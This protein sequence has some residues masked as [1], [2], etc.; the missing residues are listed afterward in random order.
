MKLRLTS[1]LLLLLC[2]FFVYESAI[3]ANYGFRDDYSLTREAH[4]E[5]GKI[6]AFTASHARPLYGVVLEPG[7]KLV[8][9]IDDLAWLR[10]LSAALI[11]G[12]GVALYRQLRR[13][14]LEDL[15]ATAISLIVMC[16]PASQVTVSWAVGWPWGF[17]LIFTV[18][19]FGL[20]NTAWKQMGF[21]RAWRIAIAIVLYMSSTLIYQSNTLFVVALL[22]SVLLLTTEKNIENI[23]KNKKE[24]FVIFHLAIL[25][26]ALIF[27]YI[28][29]KLL[30]I[31]GVFHAS[32]RLQFEADPISKLSWFL[33]QP[34]PNSIAF[35][36]LRDDFGTGAVHFW[37]MLFVVMALITLAA[38]KNFRNR[39]TFNWL[40]CILVLPWIAHSIS[41][42]AAERASGYR[43]MFALSGLAVVLLIAAVREVTSGSLRA[44]IITSIIVASFIQAYRQSYHLIAEPQ[45]HEWKMVK[46]AVA[47]MQP[48]VATCIYL[49]EPKPVDR[50]TDRVYRDEF[51]SFSSNSS[52]APD[53]MFKQ[54]MHQRFNRGIPANW[55]YCFY[56]GSNPPPSS[57]HYDQVVDMRKLKQWRK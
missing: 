17:S 55:H 27:G 31:E 20:C 13:N 7:Y 30:F 34:L 22:A 44:I 11:A 9:S 37:L 56:H 49:I 4:E 12:F 3:F 5:P 16:L 24:Q 40:L 46:N 54:A 47:K 45:A 36:T 39:N 15:E 32:G 8:R 35:L 14:G 51:G 57:D 26:S 33:S 10:L 48:G 41:L 25:F 18:L 42:I 53:E 29:L 19:G 23:S 50:S 43:T 21:S 38:Y 52:W 2:P 28:F 1:I 6:L